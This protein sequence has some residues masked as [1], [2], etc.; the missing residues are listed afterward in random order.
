M[1]TTRSFQIAYHQNC[2]KWSWNITGLAGGSLSGHVQLNQ[3]TTSSTSERTERNLS[4]SSTTQSQVW[5]LK[6]TCTSI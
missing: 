6:F 2:W 5:Q 1:P 4:L 3:S